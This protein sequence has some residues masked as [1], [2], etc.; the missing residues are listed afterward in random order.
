MR[1]LLSG[2]LFAL[3]L[4]LT[5]QGA[6]LHELSHLTSPHA[7]SLSHGDGHH[8]VA[9]DLCTACLGFGQAA[10]GSSPAPVSPPLRAGLAFGEMPHAGMAGSALDLVPPRS[11]GPPV[12]L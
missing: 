3:L 8:P 6:V 1:Q 12:A 11:R 9:A 2:L 4:L 7:Q 5:Q 10:L